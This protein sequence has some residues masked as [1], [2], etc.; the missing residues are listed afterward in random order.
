MKIKRRRYIT[1]T[2]FQFK[3]VLTFAITALLGSFVASTVFNF[4]ALRELESLRWSTHINAQTTGEIF[5]P[6]FMYV[7]VFSFL[8]VALLII[9]VAAWM[10]K[11]TRGQLNRMSNDINKIA[12]GFFDVDI[13]L[14]KKDE[15][16]DVAHAFQNMLTGIKDRLIKIR[17][18]YT[19]ISKIITGLE[20]TK[21]TQE[22]VS[23]NC[24]EIM[25]HLE[26]IEK[27]LNRFKLAKK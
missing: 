22:T 4:L 24:G 10:M 12:K 13:T 21:G 9:L 19:D 2:R 1:N 26:N 20:E 25:S 8:F 3:Y 23:K 11:K 14:R 18:S 6:L 27:E 5:N 16:K 17:D 7:A 15:F